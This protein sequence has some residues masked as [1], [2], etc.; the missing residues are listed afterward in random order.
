MPN[1]DDVLGAPVLATARSRSRQA[2]THFCHSPL[3]RAGLPHQNTSQCGSGDGSRHRNGAVFGANGA[4][5]SGPQGRHGSWTHTHRHKHSSR[6]AP[7]A[8]V[9]RVCGEP[10]RPVFSEIKCGWDMRLELTLR[11][12]RPPLGTI[13]VAFPV[14]ISSQKASGTTHDRTPAPTSRCQHNAPRQSGAA[15]QQLTRLARVCRASWIL[16]C[17]R[18]TTA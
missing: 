16:F 17:G 5:E 15:V 13:G 18:G 11:R 9:R 10:Q 6:Q 2:Q 3:Q 1:K 14:A 8:C 4:G 7:D 12:G